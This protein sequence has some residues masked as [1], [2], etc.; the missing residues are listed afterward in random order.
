MILS[1]QKEGIA[2]QKAKGIYTG[3][4]PRIQIDQKQ[5]QATV[6]R[7]KAK[8]LSAVQAAKELSLTKSTFY[9]LTKQLAAEK[10]ST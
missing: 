9:R 3:S 2:A 10:R 8:E 5:F 1:R 7:W 4:R 6:C